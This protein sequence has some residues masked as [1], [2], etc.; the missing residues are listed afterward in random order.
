MINKY[1]YFIGKIMLLLGIIFAILLVIFFV[2]TGG[3]GIITIT[4]AKWPLPVL[5]ILIL[6]GIILS[7]FCRPKHAIVK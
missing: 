1:L 5:A 7:G 2:L 6:G 4:E 3:L